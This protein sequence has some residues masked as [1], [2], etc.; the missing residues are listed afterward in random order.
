MAF[1]DAMSFDVIGKNGF[2]SS[3]PQKQQFS[4]TPQLLVLTQT[5]TQNDTDAVRQHQQWYRRNSNCARFMRNSEKPIHISFL[6]VFAR[7]YFPNE[8]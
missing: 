6:E 8:L 4:E 3:A 7:N 1:L 2:D 5:Q